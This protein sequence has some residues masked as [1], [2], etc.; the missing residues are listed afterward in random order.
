MNKKIIFTAFILSIAVL[1]LAGCTE[2]LMDRSAIK[3]CEFSLASAKLL[4]L[5]SKGADLKLNINIS[6]PNS[7]KAILDK[8]DFE[9]FANDKFLA[10]GSNSDKISIDPSSSYSLITSLFLSYANLGNFL[11]DLINQKQVKYMVKGNV[12]INTPIGDLKYP[13]KFT[14]T[15]K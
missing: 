8:F 14:K 13:V 11:K 2:F 3:E 15:Q 6:N 10:A 1:L 12:Y 4:N 7:T 9:V 5:T